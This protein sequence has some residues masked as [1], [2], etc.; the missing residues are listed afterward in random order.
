MNYDFKVGNCSEC[1]EP[2]WACDD[3]TA[4]QLAARAVSDDDTS[5]PKHIKCVPG[6]REKLDKGDELYTAAHELVIAMARMVTLTERVATISHERGACV[7]C[8]T[9]QELPSLSELEPMLGKDTLH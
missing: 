7:H 9:K 5:G 6:L 8:Q 4:L 2:V 1:N 3:G